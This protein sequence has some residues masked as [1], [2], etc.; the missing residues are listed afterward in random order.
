MWCIPY[1]SGATGSCLHQTIIGKKT[2][3]VLGNRE[4]CVQ[5]HLSFCLPYFHIVDVEW[6]LS[7]AGMCFGGPVEADSGRCATG[8]E[9]YI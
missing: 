6:I 9:G 2:P 8:L 1:S 5:R 7:A 4:V 3:T